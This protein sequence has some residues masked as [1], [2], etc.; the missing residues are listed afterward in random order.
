VNSID[1]IRGINTFEQ[2]EEARQVMENRLASK[3][4]K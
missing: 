1:E 2:L 4:L 3:V